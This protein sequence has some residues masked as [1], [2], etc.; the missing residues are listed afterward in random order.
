MEAFVPTKFPLDS[1]WERHY[2][3]PERASNERIHATIGP[4]CRILLNA[5]L[6]RRIGSPTTVLLY[7]NRKLAK[8]A[9]EPIPPGAVGAFPVVN[10]RGSYEIP[11]A[12]FCRTHG[13]TVRSTHKFIHPKITADHRLFLDLKRTTTVTR[14]RKII[15][16]P[17]NGNSI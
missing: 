11:A 14:R 12:S 16:A 3:G 13:I 15:E 8:I 17:V 9:I 7:Y 1:S 6:Y 2:G 5:N 10:R 4:K